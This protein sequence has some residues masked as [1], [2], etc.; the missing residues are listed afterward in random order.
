VPNFV[1]LN[2]P[3]PNPKINLPFFKINLLIEASKFAE[4]ALNVVSYLTS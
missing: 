1:G 4:E 2:P 3:N